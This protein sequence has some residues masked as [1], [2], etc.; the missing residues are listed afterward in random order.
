MIPVETRLLGEA[1][2]IVGTAVRVLR[3]GENGQERKILA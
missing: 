1:E 2:D 3:L